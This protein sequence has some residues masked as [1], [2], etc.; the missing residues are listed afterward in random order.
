MNSVSQSAASQHVQELERQLRIKL[1]DRG[2]RPLVLTPEGKLYYE[3]C[4]DVVRRQE[5]F[6]TALQELKGEREGVVRVA[7]IYSVGLAEMARLEEALARRQPG[8]QIKVEFLRPEKVYEAVV[9]DQADLGLVSY[10]E[11]KRDI[12]VLPWREERMVVAMCA[13]HRLSC[14]RVL[15]PDQLAG[16][17]FIG[18]DEDLP[19]GRD[20]RRFLREA[21]VEV[22]LALHF[23]NIQMM[24]E[25]VAHGSGISILPER[26]LQEDVAQGRISVVPLAPP[27]LSR[28]LGIIHLRRKNFNPP[29]QAFLALLC[30]ESHQEAGQ[31]AGLLA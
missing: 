21:G 18:F 4:R 6:F 20:V 8:A 7:S 14:E 12:K 3:F 5:E 16:E 13:R 29:A 17:D 26:I 25:A 19:I 1:L 30:E 10:P 24:K 23:D 28:P 15:E 31:L 11:A 9:T 22:N 2:R 27:G